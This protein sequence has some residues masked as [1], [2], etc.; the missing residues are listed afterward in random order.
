MRNLILIVGFLFCQKIAAQ[1]LSFPQKIQ[2]FTSD[3]GR[4]A[5]RH[6]LQNQLLWPILQVLPH[7]DSLEHQWEKAFWALEITL[8]QSDSV[9][10]KIKPVFDQYDK[11]SNAFQR[12]LWEAIYTLYPSQFE[13]EA[14][15]CLE[16]E[17]YPK[18][19]AMI[20]TYLYRI[21][22]TSGRVG[23]IRKTMRRL[24]PQWEQIPVL[25]SLNE[26]LNFAIIPRFSLTELFAQQRTHGHKVIYSFQ[27]KNRDFPGLALV[28]LPEGDFA[29]D[30][31]DNLL[32]IKHLARSISNLPSYLT[33]GNA[34]QGVYSIQG[35]AQSDNM[36]IGPSTTLL[37]YLPFELGAGQFFHRD[38][39]DST[40]TLEKYL[41]ELPSFFQKYQPMQEAFWAG[42]AGR[43]EII[44][45]GTTIDES[46]YEGKPYFPMTPSMGCLTTQER[47]DA[48]GL[49]IESGQEL[50]VQTFLQTPETKGFLIVIEIDNQNKE[51]SVE[52][53]YP[54]IAYFEQL[55]GHKKSQ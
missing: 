4:V 52:E 16:R 14:W 38:P 5:N 13:K 2:Q 27:R 21:S 40:W 30:T 12:S 11:R 50:L 28:Q 45:H 19:F 23:Q 17:R 49:L 46:F 24:F 55:F 29:R 39:A 7:N 8:N 33:N 36:Y 48:Q 43:N 20:G 54:Q 47:W 31:Q 32:S 25:R 1:S 51:V 18:N 34:P 10:W 41:Q 44:L 6:F 15:Q 3:S 9:F 35:L 42:K 26:H 22:G 53:L 37:T